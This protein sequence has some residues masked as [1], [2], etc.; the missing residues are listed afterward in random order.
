MTCSRPNLV[1]AIAGAWLAAL[2]GSLPHAA[3]AEPLSSLVHGPEGRIEFKS[4]TPA[5]Q[6]P[7][8][9]RS[10]LKQ[11]P[12]SVHG[13]LS[14]PKQSALG[15]DGKLP[16]VIL[17][18]GTGG[19][20][21][22]REHAW[23]KRLN[24]AGIAALVI[25]SFA[26]RGIKPPIYADKPNFTS[27][28]PHLVDAYTAL[29][30]LETHPRIDVSRV[31]LMGFSRGGETAV[32]AIFEPFRAGALGDARHRFAAYIPFYP[33][34]N[35]RHE[36]R[37]LASAPMLMVLVGADEMTEPAP[38]E[39]MAAWLKEKGVPIKLVVYAG[40]HHAFDRLGNIQL[41]KSYVGIKACE[42]IFD[43]DTR[44]IRRLDT[45]ELLDTQKKNDD[46]VVECRK[47][48][49]R[50]GGDAKAR[51]AAVAEVRAFLI[52]VFGK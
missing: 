10:F 52:A 31:A 13:W 8:L 1:R 45:G 49:A 27:F 6:T 21:E 37:A 46:W 9:T 5:S 36:S 39:R 2:V 17:M 26:G 19:V 32:N 28:A 23:A 15:R 41:D 38:C 7:L 50:F 43:L 48:G 12:A 35:F 25:D 47:R 11:A 42:A 29:R 24:A 20:S 4:F 18:H 44:R 16:A 40:A 22:E 33:Y 30:L 3:M 34:C 51:E 14:L